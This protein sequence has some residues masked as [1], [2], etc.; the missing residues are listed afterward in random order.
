MTH[1]VVIPL[2][3]KAEYITETLHSLMMQTKQPDELIIVDDASTDGSLFVAKDYLREYADSFGHC[4]IEVIELTENSGPGH[5]RNIGM[6]R[7]SGELISF[8]DA[9]DLYHPHLLSVA[10][11]MFSTE[12]LDLLVLGMKFIPG[13]EIYPDTDAL[14]RYLQPLGKNLY[15]L[16]DPLKAVTS[17]HFILGV[18][19]N[20]ITKSKWIRPIQYHVKSSLNEGI[21]FW[22]RVLKNI[23]A[24]TTG[25]IGLLTGDLLRVREV[26]GSL[27]RKSYTHFREIPLPPVIE[28]YKKS[29][30]IN[31]RLLMGMIGKRWYMH[32]IFS[33]QS[34]RQKALFVLYHSSLLPQ[35]V[36]YIILR[37]LSQNPKHNTLHD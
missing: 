25:K 35:Y 18:G 12:Q 31:D 30:D 6:A 13:G 29:N 11:R 37:R 10:D 22:Y 36:G 20:V 34:A 3:N 33:L 26:K 7:A 17:P 27:S 24:E 23:H 5:A 4:R 28:R 8:L 15:L 1:S 14:L 2:F 16:K 9:D 21:D 19:S 32:S